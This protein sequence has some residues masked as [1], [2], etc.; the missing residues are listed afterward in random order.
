MTTSTALITREWNDKTFLFREDGYF[1]M[2]KAAKAFGKRLDNFWAAEGTKPFMEAFSRTL[3]LSTLDLVEKVPGNRY[4]ED[5]GTWAHPKL[6]V[7]FACWLDPYFEVA[8]MLMIED[9]L[10]G[11]AEFTIVKPEESS[12]LKHQQEFPKMFDELA[13]V[14][15]EMNKREAAMATEIQQLREAM[16]ARIEALESRERTPLALVPTSNE[17]YLAKLSVFARSLQGVNVLMIKSDLWKLGYLYRQSGAYR[18]YRKHSELIVERSN[19]ETMDFYVT[20]KGQ[21][22][23]VHLN[24][25]GSLTKKKS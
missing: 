2:T 20:P 7:K 9:I 22:L 24:S 13:S 23:L 19:G 8:C 10:K 15:L 18:A 25:Q 6:A 4:I 21:E 1:N 3:N 5:R 14:L 16:A 12:T 11:A 17:T